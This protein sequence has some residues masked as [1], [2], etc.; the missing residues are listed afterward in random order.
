MLDKILKNKLAI[1]IIAII[2]LVLSIVIFYFNISLGIAEDITTPCYNSGYLCGLKNFFGE[3]ISYIAGFFM[4]IF[5]TCIIFLIPKKVSEAFLYYMFTFPLECERKYLIPSFII[6]LFLELLAFY[7]SI[8]VIPNIGPSDLTLSSE[9]LTIKVINDGPGM[10]AD[11][12]TLYNYTQNIQ[13][14]R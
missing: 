14:K 5:C 2:S 3:I 9:Q 8:F 10:Y 11:I 1:F 12:W 7:L 6:F 13:Q 4:V